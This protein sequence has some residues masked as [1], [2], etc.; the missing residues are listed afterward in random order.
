MVYENNLTYRNIVGCNMLL[1]FGYPVATCCDMLGA[2]WLKFENGTIFHATFVDIANDAVVVWPDSCNN[3][4]PGHAHWACATCCSTLQ[5]A[6]VAAGRCNKVANMLRPTVL[7][8]VL[9]E[10]AGPA[11]LGYFGFIN[12]INNVNWPP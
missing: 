7:R 3:V 10:I 2:C 4:A 8:S 11:M 9:L 5:L 6:C 1:A 12:W